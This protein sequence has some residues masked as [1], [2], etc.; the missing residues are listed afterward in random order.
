[1]DAVVVAVRVATETAELVA[2]ELFTLG[3]SAVGEQP[4]PGGTVELVADLPAAALA[5]LRHPYRI[6]DVAP[7]VADG[8]QEHAT[9]VVAGR[10][11]LRP[12]WCDS[13]A[14]PGSPDGPPVEVLLDPGAS[15]GS[16]SHPSTRMCV[17]LL[18]HP[19][20]RA[21]LD[22]AGGGDDGDV[23]DV[24]SGSGV[25]AVAAALVGAVSVT[26]I[27]VDPAARAATARAAGL[28]DVAD[29]VHVVADGLADLAAA[30]H[31]GSRPPFGLLLA[32]VLIP[33]VEQHAAD[34][35]AVAAPGAV[36]VVSGLLGSQVDRAV[37]A[38][39]AAAADRGDPDPARVV[40]VVAD[41][42]WRAVVFRLGH[43]AV[44]PV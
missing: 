32:N 18:D 6:V 27:D 1:V 43:R 5:E 23:L 3:A 12:V 25:L 19:V 30:V 11:V 35:V 7:D 20:V 28:N 10:F 15:F 26:A 36:V 13:V 8:W 16:G 39:A 17:A 42:E 29:R 21:V 38:L 34:L 44:N 9:A 31:D 4:V 14:V 40:E 37:D 22:A 24:G 33:V 2:D 41:G